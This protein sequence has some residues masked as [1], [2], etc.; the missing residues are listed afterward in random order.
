MNWGDFVTEHRVI[1]KVLDYLKGD[2][3]IFFAYAENL[4][5]VGKIIFNLK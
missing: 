1:E 3:W 4:T 2:E 5:L